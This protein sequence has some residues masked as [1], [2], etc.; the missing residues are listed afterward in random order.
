MMETK[1]FECSD[2]K[3]L[4]YRCWKPANQNQRAVVHIYHGMAE[5]SERYDRFAKYLNS[6]GIVVYAQDHRGHGYT[7][8]DDERGWFADVDGWSRVAEDGYEMDLEIVRNHPGKDLF[9]F[10][11]SMGSFLVRTLAVTHPD[12]YRGMIISGTASGK[13]LVGNIGK[14]LAKARSR[15]YGSRTPDSLLDKMSFGAFAKH[16]QPQQTNFDWLSRDAD[17]VKKYIDDPMC[18]FVCSSQFFVDLL[19]GIAFANDPQQIVKIPKA[20]PICLI[21]GMMDP[22]GEFAKGPKKVY[23]AYKSVGITDLSIHLIPDARHELLNE[24]N[25]DEIHTLIGKWIEARISR[26]NR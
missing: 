22:V 23:E 18:G 1:R 8:S 9:L 3:A 20:L 12:L 14:M 11:H 2:G 21:S 24:L 17:E 19:D 4:V 15:R 6:L 10:G 13:G 16:F 26:K 5:H 25:R 7:A